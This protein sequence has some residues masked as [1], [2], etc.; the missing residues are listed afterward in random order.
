MPASDVQL[1]ANVALNLRQA[2]Q[3]WNDFASKT[4]NLTLDSNRFLRPLGTISGGLGEFNKSLDAS[5]ARVLAFGASV[6]VFYTVQAAIREMGK[7]A[8]DVQKSLTDINVILNLSSSSLTKFGDALFDIAKNTGNSFKEASLAAT[9]LS[10]QGLSVEQTLKRTSDALILARLS[11]L[12]TTES[13]DTLTSAINSFSKEALDSS[14]VINKLAR[15]DANYAVSSK[16]LAEAIRRSASTAEDAGVSLDKLLG[17]VTAV[18]QTTARGGPVIGNALKTIF[19]RL[20][21]KDTIEKLQLLG[22]SINETQDG[23]TKL[24]AV[25]DKVKISSPLEASEIKKLTAGTFQINVLNALL[26]DLSKTYSISG[27]AAKESADATSEAVDRNE[28]LNETL[29]S[30]LNKTKVSGLQAA[31]Q[32]GSSALSPLLQNGLSTINTI[33]EG[34]A[35]K[36]TD[37]SAQIGQGI[38]RGLGQYLTGPGL[39][40]IFSSLSGLI[41]KFSIEAI[42]AIKTVAGLTR[43]EQERLN[44]EQAII[45]QIS[46]EPALRQQALQGSLSQLEVESRLLALIKEEVALREF[47]SR[48]TPATLTGISQAGYKLSSEGGG[49]SAKA[50][51]PALADFG[52]NAAIQNELSS[53][54]SLSDIRI[55]H[56]S[57]LKNVSNPAGI[58]VYNVRDEPAGL[59]QGISRAIAQGKNPQGYGIPN[60]AQLPESLNLSSERERTQFFDIF[61]NLKVQIASGI[62]GFNEAVKKLSTGFDLTAKEL[63]MFKKE[64]S[65]SY[66][67]YKE[68]T[69]QLKTSK[70]AA[71]ERT[72][73]LYPQFAIGVTPETIRNNIQKTIDTLQPKILPKKEISRIENVTS[74]IPITSID[75]SAISPSQSAILRQL[76]QK[77]LER[78]AFYSNQFE[79]PLSTSISNNPYDFVKKQY[80]PNGPLFINTYGKYG[81]VDFYKERE[82][83]LERIKRRESMGYVD[84]NAQRIAE[85]ENFIPP[86]PSIIPLPTWLSK[87][88]NYINDPKNQNKLLFASLLAP[89]ITSTISSALQNGT[90]S[91]RV[92][93]SLFEGIGDTASFGAI[94]AAFG[95]SGPIIGLAVG[96][97]LGISRVFKEMSSDLPEL[98]EKLEQSKERLSKLTDSFNI[99]NQT[100]D[101]FKSARA[102]EISLSGPKQSAILKNLQDNLINYTGPQQRSILQA[103]H[104]GNNNKI[105]DLNIQLT[106]KE[107]FE[108]Q[109]DAIKVFLN[110]LIDK[111]IKPNNIPNIAETLSAAPLG[112]NYNLLDILKTKAGQNAIQNLN[113][114][115][116][117]GDVFGPSSFLDISSLSPLFNDKNRDLFDQLKTLAKESPKELLEVFKQ[118]NTKNKLSPEDIKGFQN[119]FDNA[120]LKNTQKQ[121]DLFGKIGLENRSTQLSAISGEAESTRRVSDR[122][123]A[124][125]SITPEISSTELIRNRGFLDVYKIEE[126]RKK[127]IK[128]LE[129]R[130]KQELNSGIGRIE[131]PGNIGEEG[132]QIINDIQKTLFETISKS[133]DDVPDEVQ[134][135]LDRLSATEQTTGQKNELGNQLYIK[136]GKTLKDISEK[137][138]EFSVGRFGIEQSATE[139]SYRVNAQIPIEVANQ[140]KVPSLEARQDDLIKQIIQAGANANYKN[141]PIIR[142]LNAQLEDAGIID[143]GFNAQRELVDFDR[144]VRR[145]SR[146]Q[147][148]NY[149]G[150]LTNKQEREQLQFETTQQ[151][152]LI[153]IERDRLNIDKQI[154]DLQYQRSKVGMSEEL[155][156]LK[157]INEETI[158]TLEARRDMMFSSEFNDRRLKLSEES[159]LTRG[160]NFNTGRE[161]ISAFRGSLTYESK[162]LKRDLISGASAVGTELKTGFADAWKEFARGQKTATQALKDFALNFAFKIQ[163]KIIDIG[164]NSLFS[165]L[166]IG[167][168]FNKLGKNQGGLIGQYNYGGLVGRY[169]SGGL[170]TGGSG[171]K[172]DVA[173]NLSVGDYVLTKSAVQNIGID[174]LQKLNNS[175]GRSINVNLANT[176]DYN[177]PSRPTV[178]QFNTSPYLSDFALT[179]ENNPQN[180]IKFTKEGNLNQYLIDKKNYDL[181]KLQA[182]KQFEDQKHQAFI[183][184]LLN[185]F[186]A[187]GA[188]YAAGKIKTSALSPNARS[189][190][191]SNIRGLS[192]PINTYQGVPPSLGHIGARGGLMTEMGFV[193]GYATGGSVDNVPALL[194]GGEFVVKKSVVDRLGVGYLNALNRG[195]RFAEGGIVGNT[196]T[197][198]YNPDDSI[199]KLTSTIEKLQLAISPNRNN[200]IVNNNQSNQPTINS[201]ITINISKDGSVTS[202]SQTSTA[203]TDKNTNNTQDNIEN[204][205]KFSKLIESKYVELTIREKRPGGLLY[206]LA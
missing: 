136:L 59:N 79:R 28:K 189:V 55:G 137:A 156:G 153:R 176:Y 20:E 169:S 85:R 192:N 1:T 171:T 58:G 165:V 90:K 184:S 80:V 33:F 206:S 73:Q 102:G 132:R 97:L 160:D 22:V 7:A 103:I 106:K 205:K 112:E 60:F 193:R 62:T 154:N 145:Q 163:D 4:Q 126:S 151:G 198:N 38:L 99:F 10:R 70:Q 83:A 149:G 138:N 64:L 135:I 75:T 82:A 17:L 168:I 105:E 5:N 52:V 77:Q 158:K 57:I 24:Q 41:A 204:Y 142:S 36:S 72:N 161:M 23:M 162:D 87:G 123:L 115:Q 141:N 74:Q 181:Q 76:R 108:K 21:S 53:G 185:T 6:S 200:N 26:S 164:V 2:T 54:V 11:G 95:G 67:A 127:Q 45:G 111:G 180:A 196:T 133:I 51:V 84:L 188:T 65:S 37:L 48:I 110:N 93:G 174:K 129:S 63:E 177:N 144:P 101:I 159:I 56:S 13:I 12:S 50:K 124:L 146:F 49:L 187:V 178:G 167:G 15:V 29:A 143:A 148:F 14:E 94:G 121:I 25:A 147:Q 89:I 30:L 113:I 131:V 46:K 139:Q 16:D 91:G 32:L 166:G 117:H 175:D 122:E 96:G 19:T 71:L 197:S 88:Q 150:Q 44:I 172:D 9:E 31:N 114:K 35:D 173:A 140:F 191:A 116:T 66:K 119:F 98:Q 199:N 27:R 155:R 109:R 47:A 3:Q 34:I 202:D 68:S 40:L 183:G 130:T 195:A 43:G 78:E 179:D 120:I 128:D 69:P 125:L 42:D 81:Q 194:T 107:A 201:S 134:K 104:E 170:V 39:V 8:I 86:T 186:L 190:P 157:L 18:Q 118:I 182:I 152:L 100:A 61:A 203:N 92:A